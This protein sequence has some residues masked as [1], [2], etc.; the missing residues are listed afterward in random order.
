ME[1]EVGL[2]LSY[3]PAGAAPGDDQ[4]P[5]FATLVALRADGAWTAAPLY[6]LEDI[7]PVLIPDAPNEAALR[8]LDSEIR[9]IPALVVDRRIRSQVVLRP[10]EDAS[11]RP[12]AV[13]LEHHFRATAILYRPGMGGVYR[14]AHQFVNG[15]KHTYGQAVFLDPEDFT[16]SPL[17]SSVLADAVPISVG[18]LLAP[19]G[20]LEGL[21]SSLRFR[22]ALADEFS[23]A[24]RK[25]AGKQA[26]ISFEMRASPADFACLFGW[27]G[28]PTASL[29]TSST[30]GSHRISYLVT[31]DQMLK[32]CIKKETLFTMY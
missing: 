11:A 7:D 9:Q 19:A 20:P 14:I 8:L 26:S 18:V 5:L 28:G 30:A 25:C 21:A 15:D 1:V 32:P 22:H 12:V 24:L 29:K 13:V 10:A 2:C 23:G 27:P 17:R 3:L 4:A 31:E 6:P 16:I